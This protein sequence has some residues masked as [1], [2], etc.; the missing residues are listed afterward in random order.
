MPNTLKLL[1]DFDAHMK[2]LLPHLQITYSF[3]RVD[4]GNVDRLTLRYDIESAP[5]VRSY[6]DLGVN[7]LETFF[8]KQ[9]RFLQGHFKTPSPPAPSAPQAAP[10][11]VV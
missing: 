7:D 8:Q 5:P 10:R 3:E 1:A 6:V 4:Y 11:S 2:R 9:E